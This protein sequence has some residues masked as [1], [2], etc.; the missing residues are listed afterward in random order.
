MSKAAIIYWTGT[1]NTEGM[2]NAIA[3]GLRAG[4]AEADVFAVSDAP[5]LDAYEKVAFGCPAMG[6]EVLE[7]AEFDPYFS[8]EE[9]KLG[10]KKVALFGSYGWGDGQWMRDWQDRVSVDG[11]LLFEEGLMANGAPDEA[12]CAA[13]GERFAA[14]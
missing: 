11:A 5:A 14:F 10:G 3:E 7:E 6:D 9:A 4:G 2:A 12:V 1:G 13:F 8:A